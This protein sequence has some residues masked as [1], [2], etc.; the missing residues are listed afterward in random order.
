[1]KIVVFYLLLVLIGFAV[2]VY[3]SM[4]PGLKNYNQSRYNALTPPLRATAAPMPA[5]SPAS[6]DYVDVVDY[7]WATYALT[8]AFLICA[9][10][11]FI[12]SKNDNK[13]ISIG[14]IAILMAGS[15]S[16]GVFYG[17]N[18][19]VPSESQNQFK[20]ALG[21]FAA[22]IL[23]ILVALLSSAEFQ[24]Y[25]FAIIMFFASAT[26]FTAT[27]LLWSLETKFPSNVDTTLWDS[28]K[29]PGLIAAIVCFGL[30]A[31]ALYTS[32]KKQQQRGNLDEL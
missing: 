3:W 18:Q 10:L 12:I 25:T 26:L 23:L 24:S 2:G 7:Q 16:L 5:L 32:R 14:T 31:L 22:G 21:I 30:A 15:Y 13:I 4:L 6:S 20:I 17:Y 11:C 29:I 27:V 9:G 28:A 19:D 8:A 1:M